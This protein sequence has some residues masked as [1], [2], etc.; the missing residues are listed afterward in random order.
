MQGRL[1]ALCS[2]G[3]CGFA[4]K[5]TPINSIQQNEQLG[6]GAKE[7][8]SEMHSSHLSLTPK[9]EMLY[10]A[11]EILRRPAKNISEC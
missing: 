4:A 2:E 8:L 3:L 11:N 10:K 9:I 5:V 7:K 6:L 1:V